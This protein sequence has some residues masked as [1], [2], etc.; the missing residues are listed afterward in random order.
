M[1]S[2]T[3]ILPDGDKIRRAVVRTVGELRQAL[4]GKVYLWTWTRE[5]DPKH[6]DHLDLTEVDAY[7][8]A[9][10]H[11]FVIAEASK[12]GQVWRDK[13]LRAELVGQ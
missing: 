12:T 3:L 6:C 8:T 7:S 9:E 10:A 1:E 13:S 2:I 11:G 5:T 4:N